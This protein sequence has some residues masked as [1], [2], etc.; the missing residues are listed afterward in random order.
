MNE[1]SVHNAVVGVPLQSPKEC[2]WLIF[3]CLLEPLI[4]LS[5]SSRIAA[6]SPLL[7]GMPSCSIAQVT[8]NPAVRMGGAG[9]ACAVGGWA[10]WSQGC[11]DPWG[12]GR[13][14]IPLAS[15]GTTL[16]EIG[17]MSM[18]EGGGVEKYK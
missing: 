10:G 18:G 2:C 14:C 13:L 5:A 15:R 9:V 1:T 3:I 16:S 11:T 12:A 4:D 6:G 7:T 8:Q 17:V